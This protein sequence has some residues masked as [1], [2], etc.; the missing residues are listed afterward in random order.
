MFNIGFGE[1]I[2]VFIIALV[3]LG[4][5]KLPEFSKKVAKILKEI[6]KLIGNF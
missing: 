3:V 2:I 5:E 1:L 4:P 6:K